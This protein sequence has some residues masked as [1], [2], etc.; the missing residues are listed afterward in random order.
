MKS[1][2]E[3]GFEI[4]RNSELVSEND[5]WLVPS[6][7][8]ENRRYHV[9]QEM[10]AWSCDCPD[11]HY[12]SVE[13]K[14]IHAVKFW[15]SLRE[16]MLTFDAVKEEETTCVYC[17]SGNT[18]KNGSR[19]NEYTTKQRYRC[20]ECGKSFVSDM[21]IKRKGDGK[22]ITLTM[23]LYFKGISLRKIQDHL[24]QFYGMEIHHETIRRWINSYMGIIKEHTDQFQ[25]KVGGKWHTDEMM[26]KSKGKLLWLWN[27]MDAET[28][29]ML[30]NNVTKERGSLDA[31]AV[32]KEAKE[33]AGQKPEVMITDGLAGYPVAFNKVF[34]DHHQ[35]SKHICIVGR[36]KQ[37]NNNLIER[38]NGTVRERNKVQR[39]L[40][41]FG[42][43]KLFFKN[44]KTYYNFVRPHQALDGKTP[45]QEAGFELGIGGNRWMEL[46]EKGVKKV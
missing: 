22:A 27:C 23:D 16:Q 33:T 10:D 2:E 13:C 21:F 4:A 41:G 30:A 35:S 5:G 3:K 37:T 7:T 46:I 42:T 17:G 38:L 43:S 20:R 34:Y 40:K 32:F 29:F 18:V 19:K 15:L 6:Q 31:R 39:G 26:F 14:H 1:R 24:R 11:H 44:Y 45:A 8:E 9:N 36:R 25:P 12:R 28:R